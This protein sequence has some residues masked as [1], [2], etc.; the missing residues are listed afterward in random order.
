MKAFVAIDS[1]KLPYQARMG[2]HFSFAKSPVPKPARSHA[3]VNFNE[4]IMNNQ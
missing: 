3:N 2:K 4:S 1:V